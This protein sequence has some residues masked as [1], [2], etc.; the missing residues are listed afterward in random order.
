MEIGMFCTSP[1]I[2]EDVTVT[3][4][5]FAAPDAVTAAL[6]QCVEPESRTAY[7]RAMALLLRTM[8]MAPECVASNTS[9]PVPMRIFDSAS[10]SERSPFTP[11]V[12]TP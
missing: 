9:K 5:K 2:F 4:F 1:P 7:R 3:D 8:P 6:W 12:V 10:L 11:F